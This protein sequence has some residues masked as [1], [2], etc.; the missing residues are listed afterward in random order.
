MDKAETQLINK[1]IDDRM[2]NDQVKD[3]TLPENAPTNMNERINNRVNEP[4]TNKPEHG[5]TA[6]RPS[7]QQAF[8]CSHKHL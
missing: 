5:W 1:R 7:R 6:E 4:A 2:T 3:Q 8:V